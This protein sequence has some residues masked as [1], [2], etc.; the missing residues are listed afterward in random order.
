[1][2]NLPPDKAEIF[3]KLVL[4]LK[5]DMNLAE[6]GLIEVLSDLTTANTLEELSWITIGSLIL[7]LWQ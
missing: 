6:K 2:N 7:V 1:M 5:N 4:D 3:A